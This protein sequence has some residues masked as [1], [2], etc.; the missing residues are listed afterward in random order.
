MNCC[1]VIHP[2][3]DH[4]SAMMS[5]QHHIAK[6][7]FPSAVQNTFIWSVSSCSLLCWVVLRQLIDGAS[8]FSSP[9]GFFALLTFVNSREAKSLPHSAS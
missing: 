6:F 3:F 7:A 4:L 2:V 5:V 9:K 8:F 1:A